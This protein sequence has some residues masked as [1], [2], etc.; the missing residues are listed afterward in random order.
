MITPRAAVSVN[1]GIVVR[2][3]KEG[4][5]NEGTVRYNFGTIEEREFRKFPCKR[6]QTKQ[7]V[8]YPACFASRGSPVRSRSRPPIFSIICGALVRPHLSKAGAQLKNCDGR[9][10]QWVAI[11][12]AKVAFP[13]AYQLLSTRALPFPTQSFNVEI[14]IDASRFQCSSSKVSV[15]ARQLTGGRS[16]YQKDDSVQG[17]VANADVWDEAPL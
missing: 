17:S 5:F 8:F 6:H 12:S 2:G 9:R 1:Q 4:T 14:E 15:N 7:L 16:L 10:T 11:S 13:S 3:R